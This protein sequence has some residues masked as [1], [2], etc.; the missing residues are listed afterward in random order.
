KSAIASTGIP[1]GTTTR[2]APPRAYQNSCSIGVPPHPGIDPSGEASK[3]IVP[4]PALIAKPST[5]RI[6]QLKKNQRASNNNVLLIGSIIA[7]A[8]TRG[9]LAVGPASG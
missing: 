4:W 1:N 8:D 3:R 5:T 6:T 7:R 9:Q 2:S